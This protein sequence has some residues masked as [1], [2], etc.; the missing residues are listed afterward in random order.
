[1]GLL[2]TLVYILLGWLLSLCGAELIEK[3]V[4]WRND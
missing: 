3:I 1:M 4:R 2:E